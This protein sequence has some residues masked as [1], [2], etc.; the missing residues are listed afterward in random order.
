MYA[1]L[2][3]VICIVGIDMAVQH[4]CVDNFLRESNHKSHF[5]CSVGNLSVIGSLPALKQL[6]PDS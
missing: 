4:C 2:P 5:G 6:T 3:G 1:Y